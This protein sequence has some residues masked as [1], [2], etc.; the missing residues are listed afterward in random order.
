MSRGRGRR[1][2]AGVRDPR[3]ATSRLVHI[4]QGPGGLGLSNPEVLYE[5]VDV[6]V[7]YIEHGASWLRV[8]AIAYLWKELGTSCVHLPQTPPS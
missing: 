2:L 5:F 7:E 1:D 3:R 4:L 6:V 8:D